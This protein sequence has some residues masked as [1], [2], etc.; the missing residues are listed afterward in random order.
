MTFRARLTVS[1][2]LDL[3]LLLATLATTSWF[4][5]RG[6][7][8]VEKALGLASTKWLWDMHDNMI[9]HRSRMAAF[10]AGPPPRSLRE[11]YAEEYPWSPIS[12]VNR[13]PAMDSV[14]KWCQEFQEKR[15]AP[16]L[17]L[18]SI[19]LGL[20]AVRRPGTR[21]ARWSPGRIA[22]SIAVLMPALL[23]A[24]ELLLRRLSLMSYGE[25]HDTMYGSWGRDG[26]KVGMAIAAAWLLMLFGG[27]WR[28]SRGWRELIGLALGT[29][30]VIELLWTTVLESVAQFPQ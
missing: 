15:L 16:L 13:V 10:H 19:G 26:A 1:P 30:W 29:A 12:W 14:W 3:V 17:T 6:E 2:W 23:V 18:T 24:E 5:T 4:A 11:R 20:I 21:R 22:A 8:E 27:R 28:A 25:Y 7:R 9:K